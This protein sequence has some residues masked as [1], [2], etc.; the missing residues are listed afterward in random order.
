MKLNIF[1]DSIFLGELNTHVRVINIQSDEIV[2]CDSLQEAI[3]IIKEIVD[4]NIISQLDKEYRQFINKQELIEYYIK[5]KTELYEVINNEYKTLF[6][7]IK[8]IE[9]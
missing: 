7:I 9:N 5:T 1:I 8:F 3:E 6:Y 4:S 2:F